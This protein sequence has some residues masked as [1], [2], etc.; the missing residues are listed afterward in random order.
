MLLLLFFHFIEGLDYIRIYY[1]SEFVFSLVRLLELIKL[2][3]K[4]KKKE[5]ITILLFV[6]FWMIG[7]FL[8]SDDWMVFVRFSL[9][10]IRGFLI[11]SN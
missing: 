7:G 8:I 4:I 9:K 5:F 11:K 6:W 2:I 1:L 10:I 3:C